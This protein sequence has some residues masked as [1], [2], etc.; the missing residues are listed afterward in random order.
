[1]PFRLDPRVALLDPLV[2]TQILDGLQFVQVSI[3]MDRIN[4]RSELL[5]YEW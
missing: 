1:M 2:Q 4:G 5:M 3:G